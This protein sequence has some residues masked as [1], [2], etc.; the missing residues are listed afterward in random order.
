MGLLNNLQKRALPT[1]IANSVHKGLESYVEFNL[2]KY[3]NQDSK[4]AFLI[5]LL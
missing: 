4:K 3:L 5:L 1:N 2:L